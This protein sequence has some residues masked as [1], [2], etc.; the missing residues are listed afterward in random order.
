M[1]S[2][3]PIPAGGFLLLLFLRDTEYVGAKMKIM[4]KLRLEAEN[5]LRP[6]RHHRAEVAD[7]VLVG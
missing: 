7:G 6:L 1:K 4:V 2:V 3:P 5:F